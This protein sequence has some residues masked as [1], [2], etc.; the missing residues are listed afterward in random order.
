MTTRNSSGGDGRQFENHGP[1]GPDIIYV[2]N[3]AVLREAYT[4]FNLA[5]EYARI[6]PRITRRRLI[7]WVYDRVIEC[8]A[9]VIDY[10]GIEI[11]LLRIDVDGIFGD[12]YSGSWA[13]DFLAGRMRR[14]RLGASPK[15]AARIKLLW[16]ALAAHDPAA[17]QSVLN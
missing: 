15:I 3:P 10:D 7:D 16:I 4:I 17:A 2:P 14:R 6:Q 5:I 9:V 1:T 8:N 13:G 11:D 12:D